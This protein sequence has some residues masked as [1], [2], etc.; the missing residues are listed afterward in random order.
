MSR[1]VIQFLDVSDIPFTLAN[2]SNKNNLKLVV[3]NTF[4]PMIISPLNLGAHV[5]IHSMTKF[6]NGSLDCVADVQ[7]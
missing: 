1:S 4:S 7:F 6:I 3:D 2:I 5:V